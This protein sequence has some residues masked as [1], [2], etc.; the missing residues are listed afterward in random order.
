[1]LLGFLVGSLKSN[2]V[3]TCSVILNTYGLDEIGKK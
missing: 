2:L 3:R 1:M